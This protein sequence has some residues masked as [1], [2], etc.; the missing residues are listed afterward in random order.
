[1]MHLSKRFAASAMGGF[2]IN[3]PSIKDK[4]P[5]ESEEYQEM[6]KGASPSR[7]TQAGRIELC[8]GLIEEAT[9]C[10]GNGDKDCVTKLIE[11]L[12]QNQC[13]NGNAVGNEI[14]SSVK[15]VVHK[16][17]LSSGDEL[18]CE[19]L[20][21][22]M[23][24]R[25]A[26]NWVRDAL[27]MNTKR[28]NKW[29][30]RCN[31]NGESRMTRNNIIE[32]IE[33]LLRDELG[34]DEIVMCNE[35]WR[36]IGVDTDAFR[37]HGI[38]PCIW[39]IGLEGLRSLKRPYWLGLRASDLAMRRREKGVELKLR[40]TNTIDAVFF[41]MLLNIVK[42][43]RPEIEWGRIIPGTR[44]AT[45]SIALSFYVDLG[46]NEWPWPIN[47]NADEFE[48]IL[49]GFNDERLAMFVA[50]MI[51]GD[52]L[53][54]CIFKD[55]NAYVH[56]GITACKKCHKSYILNVLRRVIAERF[57][58]AGSI[59]S[60][61]AANVL[62]FSGE[63]A[64]RLLR[65][66]TKY[67]HHPLKRLRAELI[68]ALYDERISL[69]VFGKLYEQT[70]YERRAPDVKRSHGLEAL[71]QAAPQTHTHGSKTIFQNPNREI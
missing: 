29:L 43:P 14:V 56:V 51:D 39:L 64:I 2:K 41:P 19:L 3:G 50:G 47:L 52:G 63:D 34:W 5:M 18:R 8:Q 12:V 49:N 28:L 54:R 25:M 7:P 44:H 17:W 10:L 6:N 9:K 71:A 35:L 27:G 23:E 11:E 46:P 48:R 53:V 60:Q 65:R 57:G 21:R 15:D 37:R 31:I 69:E 24:L 1:M 68:L 59:E 61:R 22:L 62:V 32:N 20:M 26:R 30:V 70:E 42:T 45:K 58:I 36:F 40:T 16:L 13:H 38:E 67:M 55:N 33:D 4:G 66:V